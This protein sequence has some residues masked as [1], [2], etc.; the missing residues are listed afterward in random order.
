VRLGRLARLIRLL[1]AGDLDERALE[2][3]PALLRLVR[4]EFVGHVDEAPRFGGV[5]FGCGLTAEAVITELD[6]A[7]ERLAT[8]AL[9]DWSEQVDL[10]DLTRL[11]RRFA[12]NLMQGPGKP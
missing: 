4:A 5:V 3:P 1:P 6:T 7:R 9:V 2:S 12:D 8:I 10:K 11:L